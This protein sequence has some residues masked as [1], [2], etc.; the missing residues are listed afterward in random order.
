MK[1]RIFYYILVFLTVY[2]LVYIAD[3]N[4]SKRDIESNINELFKISSQSFHDSIRIIKDIYLYYVYDSKHI[5][6][7]LDMIKVDKDGEIR[8]SRDLINIEN[9]QEYYN[10]Q[11]QSIMLEDKEDFDLYVADSIWNNQLNSSGYDVEAIL[12]LSAKIMHKI[13]DTATARITKASVTW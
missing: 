2:S 1:K 5:N 9:P 4:N 13:H 7:R 8:I 10:K 11:L 3:Y 6:K 12:L